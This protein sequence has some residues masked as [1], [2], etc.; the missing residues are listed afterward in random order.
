MPPPPPRYLALDLAPFAGR[1][2]ALVEGEII[3]VGET[4]ADAQARARLSRPQRTATLLF[5][6]LPAVTDSTPSEQGPIVFGDQPAAQRAHAAVR[7]MAPDAVMV[8]GAVRDWLLGLAQHDLDYVLPGDA[9]SVARR[10]ADANGWAFYPL[11]TGR[12]TGRIVWKQAGE[13]PFIIDMATV[14]GGNLDAD[15][16]ARDFTINAIAL[17]PDGHTYDPLEGIADLAARRLRP[18]SPTSLLSDPLRVLRGVRMLFAFHLQPAP[19][20]ED[21]VRAALSGFAAVSAERQRDELCRLLALPEPHQVL[22]YVG[23]WDALPLLMPEL[24]ALQGVEQSPPHIYDAYEHTLVALRWMARID[25]LLRQELRP[26]DE[27]E[28]ALADGLAPLAGRLQAYL[29]DDLSAGRP[30]WL[31][32]RIAALAHD[33]GKA[34]TG[35]M[36]AAT[37]SMSA[38]ATVDA[39]RRIHFYGHEAV[40][41]RL[42]AAW[43]DRF[44]FSSGEIDFVRQV[45]SGHMRPMTL[46]Q[47][48]W[49]P[50]RRS[51]YRLYRDFGRDTPALALLYAADTLATYGP[52]IDRDI[53]RQHVGFVAALLK[54]AFGDDAG[55]MAPKSLLDGREVMALTGIS[56]GPRLG[57]VLERLR[58]AQAVGE[59][60]TPFEAEAFVQRLAQ[61]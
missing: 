6:A 61:A 8:G 29:G 33:W 58:E 9:L 23:A 38:A 26:S 22:T 3:A 24:V 10:V 57:E 43:L 42:A 40:S 25:R 27:I 51:L 2:V 52:D 35:S 21:L 44:H 11:D 18:C 15:L 37:G 39:G 50:S 12:G 31:A 4:A 1:Y 49:T 60:M 19:G 45:C 32:L 20:L 16:R 54:P 55:L 36:A 7:R 17:L 14:V 5:V 13:D 41:A 53:W 47:G 28:V 34:T 30:R 56:P 59:V 46:A 48:T